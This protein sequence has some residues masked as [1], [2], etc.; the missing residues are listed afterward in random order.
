MAVW[1]LG[2]LKPNVAH[3]QS[4]CRPRLFDM[5]SDLALINDSLP[6]FIALSVSAE[7]SGSRSLAFIQATG[8]V[9]IWDI[10]PLARLSGVIFSTLLAW[11]T[12]P[13]AAGFI[14]S[15]G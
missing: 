1:L 3:L 14:F 2:R 13:Q 10:S 5:V 12:P 15:L 6:S 9:P 11:R 4:I 8:L 7:L